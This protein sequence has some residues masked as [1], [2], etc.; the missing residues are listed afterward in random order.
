MKTEPVY[1]KGQ[2]VLIGRIFVVEGY[3]GMMKKLEK[4]EKAIITN[5]EATPSLGPCYTV[6]WVNKSLPKPAIKYWEDD[7]LCPVD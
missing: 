6:E 5:V 2:T 3:T 7:I 1:K 4:P